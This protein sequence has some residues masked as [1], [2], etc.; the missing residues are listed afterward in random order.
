MR[1]ATEY[2]NQAAETLGERG[3]QY[4]KEGKQER[5]MAQIVALFNALFPETPLTEYQGWRFM[6]FVKMVRGKRAPHEDSELDGVG[7]AALAAECRMSEG[8]FSGSAALEPTGKVAWKEPVRQLE[9]TPAKPWD[10]TDAPDWATFVGRI[11]GSFFW[12]GESWCG[13]SWCGERM[14]QRVGLPDVAEYDE[15]MAYRRERFTVVERRPA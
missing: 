11:G 4:D 5:S 2:L 15:S 9:P 6:Q 10:W 3:K 7:Y 1:Q 14:Y 12:C 13:E 8:L